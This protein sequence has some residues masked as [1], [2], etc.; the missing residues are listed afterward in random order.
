ME[1]DFV[2]LYKSENHAEYLQKQFKIMFSSEIYL[3]TKLI[4]RDG[5]ISVNKMLAGLVLPELSQS[6]RFNSF[7]EELSVLLPQHGIAEVKE[8]INQV[9]T[10]KSN[11]DL[12]LNQI[13]P[14]SNDYLGIGIKE[15]FSGDENED[16]YNNE[17]Y[18]ENETTNQDES[19]ENGLNKSLVLFEGEKDNVEKRSIKANWNRTKRLV[20][21]LTACKAIFDREIFTANENVGQCL[22]CSEKLD[23]SDGHL[24]LKTHLKKHSATYRQ[25]M[26]KNRERNRKLRRGIETGILVFPKK[27][28]AV[29]DYFIDDSANESAT[30]TACSKVVS[31]KNLRRHLQS[32]HKDRFHELIARENESKA[33]KNKDKYN[34]D[35][36]LQLENNLKMIDVVKKPASV[37]QSFVCDTC[38]KTFG[39]KD[40]LRGHM[41]IVH[42]PQYG[43]HKCD[44]CD[45]LLATAYQL[46]SHKKAQH[47]GH[48]VFPC[49]QCGKIL[50]SQ[51]N[52]NMHVKTVHDQIKDF[53]CPHCDYSVSSSTALSVHVKSAHLGVKHSCDKCDAEFSSYSSLHSHKLVH[54]EN[55]PYV[56]QICGKG[57]KKKTHCEIHTRNIHSTSSYTCEDCGKSFKS[58]Q[59]LLDHMRMHDESVQFPCKYCSKKFVTKTKLKQHTNTHTGERPYVCPYACGKAYPSCD[60]LSHHKNQCGLKIDVHV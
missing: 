16:F 12:S 26:V 18:L 60:Q 58:E 51:V 55:R 2:K 42:D 43:K 29:W 19:I 4:C 37:E 17:D 38:G 14:S 9:F 34:Y 25:F 5:N 49:E 22:E 20:E 50:S 30:C 23:I 21:F 7:Q 46:A 48:N 6:L 33:K 56:C 27:S 15:E 45:K 32:T 36:D 40:S 8:L 31:E 10:F 44:K 39:S 11:I 3:D 13:D 24:P 1:Q 57:F 53:S 41:R 35:V 59:Y 47:E 54:S 52:L 28:S